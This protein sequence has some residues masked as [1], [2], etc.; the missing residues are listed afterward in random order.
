MGKDNGHNHGGVALCGGLGAYHSPTNKS[1]PREFE[2]VSIEQILY[3][4]ANPQNVD[5]SKARWFIPS[6]RLTRSHSEQRESGSF[7]F[8]WAD[9]DDPKS[10]TLTE[11]TESLSSILETDII[12]YTTKSATK[13]NQKCRILIQLMVP[14]DGGTFIIMQRLLNECLSDFIGVMPDTATERAGQLCYLPNKGHFYDYQITEKNILFSGD[15]W[16]ARINQ[17]RDKQAAQENERKSRLETCRLKME[18]KL[19]QGYRSPIVAFN[20]SYPIEVLLEQYGY[21]QIGERWLSPNSL[22]GSPGVRIENNKWYSSHSSDLNIG[23]ESSDGG[24]Y[25][26]AF[27]LFKHWEHEGN[28][29]NALKAAGVMFINE[30]GETITQQNERNEAELIAKAF[31][32]SKSH[33]I[34]TRSERPP[35]QNV[36]MPIA[37]FPD[38]KV[39]K[40]GAVRLKDTIG[41]I[42][43]MLHFYQIFAYYDVIKK[44][45]FIRVP[46]LKSSLDNFDNNSMTHC[47]S[48]AKL[49]EIPTDQTA[50]YI[51]LIADENQKNPIADWIQSRPWDGNTR[52][53]DL[54]NSITLE[55]DY[56]IELRNTL[57]K[58][59]LISA[60][61]A[62]YTPSGFHSRGVL[63]LQG[64]QSIG[65]TSWLKSLVPER[66]LCDY[67]V[68]VDHQLDP[69]NKDSMFIAI[70]HWLVELGEL[71]ASF[72]KDISRIKG[73]ITSPMDK[74]RRPYSRTES[75]YQRRTVFFAS[76][77]KSDFLI[78]DTG[79]TRFWTIRVRAANYRHNLDMQQV[80]AE[81]KT[82]FDAQEQWWLTKEEENR[83]ELSNQDNRSVSAVGDLIQAKIAF[84]CPQLCDYRR[85]SASEVLREI[86][87]DKPTNAQ[88]KEAGS[89]L[90]DLLGEP[91]TSKGRRI[92]KVPPARTTCESR[93]KPSFCAVCMGC[94][95]GS[96][97]S[98]T[99]KRPFG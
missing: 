12:G 50:S 16:T 4:L 15:L 93:L 38:V 37:R 58:R 31:N 25:G 1:D 55:D 73:F 57:I 45:V 2:A 76:V 18:Q 13:D 79:N 98:K 34:Q 21:E 54:Y 87:Y 42:R 11:I 9:I 86:G 96:T 63:T 62:I 83:L 28:E 22:S 70:S 10:K 75:E 51:C 65:K 84:D 95:E 40:T 60:V 8:L 49:N 47:I 48:L 35:N 59:W 66:S 36:Q 39:S 5:K 6:T 89:A 80:W 74:I 41:N 19:Q 43:E 24:R 53:Q 92:W 33:E 23:T 78:D 97:T 14:V 90:R 27:D 82:L 72:K 56:S 71:E 17:E 46:G 32:G 29:N 68:K 99:P 44:K 67:A 91:T 81:V 52:L 3:A 69:N 88:A 64:M 20:N 94:A 85:M 77:N 61:A 26:D 30:H 7:H